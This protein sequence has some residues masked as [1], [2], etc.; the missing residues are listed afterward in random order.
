[1]PGEPTHQQ[2]QKEERI[3]K[4]K[5]AVNLKVADLCTELE[6]ELGVK[7]TH[8]VV[9]SLGYLAYDKIQRSTEDFEAFA[10]HARRTNVTADDVKL[11]TRRNSNLHAHLASLQKEA[12]A[13]KPVS[14]SK[15]VN[16]TAK[17]KKKDNNDSD[18]GDERGRASASG[19]F[20]GVQRFIQPLID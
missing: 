14:G 20:S 19:S 11:L 2:L 17:K 3:Q 4:L 1:M 10:Q 6:S 13:S 12:L 5:A 15:N 8:E 9:A 18:N 7:F 16:K